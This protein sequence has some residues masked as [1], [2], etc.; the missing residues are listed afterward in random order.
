MFGVVV[1][2]LTT[3]LDHRGHPLVGEPVVHRSVLAPGDDEA[4]PAQAGEVIGHLWLRFSQERGQLADRALA[5]GHELER[6][7]AGAIAEHAEVLG[8]QVG[9]RWAVRQAEGGV[10]ESGVHRADGNSGF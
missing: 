5:L 3:E 2:Q 6:A 9:L 8:E 7:Q 10:W 4:A 1:E